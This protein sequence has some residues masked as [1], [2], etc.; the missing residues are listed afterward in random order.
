MGGGVVVG[1]GAFV[2]PG[3]GV[4]VAAVVVGVVAWFWLSNGDTGSRRVVVPAIASRNAAAMSASSRM[5][6][7][8]AIERIAESRRSIVFPPCLMG[9][10][11]CASCFC[12]SNRLSRTTGFARPAFSSDERA[13]RM[14]V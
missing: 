3:T 1:A 10:Y 2:W 9:V 14:V 4:A 12:H 8:A 5:P 11:D 13:A 7:K 6:S